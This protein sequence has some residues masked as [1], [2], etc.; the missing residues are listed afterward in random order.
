MQCQSCYVAKTSLRQVLNERKEGR[1]SVYVGMKEGRG[2][3]AYMKDGNGAIYT[4]MKDG[5]GAT[6]CR[7]R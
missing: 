2:A 3:N 4:Y 1:G 5:K 6:I 7:A